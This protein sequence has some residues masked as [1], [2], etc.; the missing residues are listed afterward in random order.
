[1]KKEKINDQSFLKLL[2]DHLT[3]LVWKNGEYLTIDQGISLG[4]SLSPLLSAIYLKELDKAFERKNVYYLRY[5]DDWV[6]LAKTKNNLRNAVKTAYKILA[7][8][9]LKMHPD[10][11]FIG[12]IAK[13]FNFLGFLF[14]P[15]GLQVCN[16]AI[17]RAITK[18][19]Q[20][21]EQG[22]S[23]KRIEEYWQRWQRWAKS[24]LYP[25]QKTTKAKLKSEVIS[26]NCCL[27]LT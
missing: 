6:V 26:N 18:S 12:R 19:L 1:M 5:M 3:R 17:H 4:C 9:K 13:G 27:V 23:K 7:K 2:K 10:K 8:L 21:Y 25:K 20:L 15:E 14:K 22:A 24:V 11:T 16:E